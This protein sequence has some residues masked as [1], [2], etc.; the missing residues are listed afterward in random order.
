MDAAV[1]LKNAVAFESA[2]KYESALMSLDEALALQPDYADA[3]LIKAVILGKF[4]RCSEAL[5][6]YD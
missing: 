1:K 6:C 5:K 4:G 2:G 3:W